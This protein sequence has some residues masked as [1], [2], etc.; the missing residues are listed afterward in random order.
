VVCQGEQIVTLLG[1]VA[2]GLG[3]TIVPEMAAASPWAQ[4]CVFRSLARPVPQRTLC[5]VWH[6]HRYRPAVLRHFI[7]Q[8]RHA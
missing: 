6:R 5:A 2:A 7:A 4:G 8:L 1:L 3:V